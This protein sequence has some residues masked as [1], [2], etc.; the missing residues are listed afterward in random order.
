MLDKAT[1]DRLQQAFGG[2]ALVAAGGG[3]PG[4]PGRN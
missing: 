1:V 4:Y 3:Y 2:A